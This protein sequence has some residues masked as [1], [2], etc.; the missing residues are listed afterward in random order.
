MIRDDVL[1]KGKQALV[2]VVPPEQLDVQLMERNA[3]LEVLERAA[4][5]NVFLTAL[6]NNPPGVLKGYDLSSEHKTALATGDI[7]SIEKWVGPLDERLKVWMKAR[8]K[9]E[10]L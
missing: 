2:F 10:N 9:R 3:I 1:I 7:E 6:A 8:L 4:E 5:D